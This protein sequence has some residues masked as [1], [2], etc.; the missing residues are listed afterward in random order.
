MALAAAWLGRATGQAAYV[1]NAGDAWQA[2]A[3]SGGAPAAWDW[4]TQWWA[5]GLLLW[6]L[7]GEAG[8]RAQARA[9]LAT[10]PC[11]CCGFWTVCAETCFAY[12]TL[13][14]LLFL[15]FSSAFCLC[16]IPTV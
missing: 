12:D 5:A 2:Q 13:L 10:L 6:Q 8:Y 11:T 7:T 16:V 3:A 4:D 1:K 15:I 9:S 14:S